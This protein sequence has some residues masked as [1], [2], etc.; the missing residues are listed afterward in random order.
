MRREFRPV[1][2]LLVL[3]AVLAAIF[4]RWPGIDL[5]VTG[6]FY[7]ARAHHFDPLLY[8]L[9]LSCKRG[10]Y[11]FNDLWLPLLVAGNLIFFLRRSHTRWLGFNRAQWAFLLAVMALGPG[12]SVNVAKQ[13]FHRPRPLEIV[14]FGGHETYVPPLMRGTEHGQSFF[15]GHAASGFYFCAFALLERRHRKRRYAFGL[16]LGSVIGLSR[17][18]MGAHFLS[19]ILFSAIVMLL[20]M[21]ALRATL[22]RR[23]LTP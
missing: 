13:Y 9:G 15:S 7:D 20:V 5:A 14:Q 22:F 19:D 16:A 18:V 23:Q 8:L 17:I 4:N 21:Y 6:W 3:G 12:L 11:V 1:V 10:I 2:A